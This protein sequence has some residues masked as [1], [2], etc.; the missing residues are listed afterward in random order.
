MSDQ[1]KF[2]EQN[3]NNQNSTDV[4]DHDFSNCTQHAGVLKFVFGLARALINLGHLLW[5]ILR[6]GEK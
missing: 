2:T 5:H 4:G 6:K 3:I 1:E